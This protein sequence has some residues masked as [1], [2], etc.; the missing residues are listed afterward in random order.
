MRSTV[1]SVQSPNIEEPLKFIRETN[2]L[3][4]ILADFTAKVRLIR[5]QHMIRVATLA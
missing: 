1:Y 5:T 2:D 4:T 3:A